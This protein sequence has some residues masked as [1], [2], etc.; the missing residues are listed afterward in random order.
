MT[1]GAQEHRI[2]HNGPPASRRTGPFFLFY[3]FCF[4]RSFLSVI[5]SDL[6]EDF[7][8]KSCSVDRGDAAADV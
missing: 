3:Q 2:F 8:G 1:E 6:F 4:G 5:I 7:C